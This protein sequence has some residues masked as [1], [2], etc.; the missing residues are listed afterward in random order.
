MFDSIIKV[1]SLIIPPILQL[2]L[3]RRNKR[4]FA[5]NLIQLNQQLKKIYENG[6]LLID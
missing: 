5:Q 4:K 3:K 1:L 2:D 6:M